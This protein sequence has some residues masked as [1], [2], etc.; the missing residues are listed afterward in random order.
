MPKDII[1][2]KLIRAYA[3]KNAIAHEGKAN[4]GAV[5]SA[6]F[7]EGLKR[8]DV[9]EVMPTVTRVSIEVS[10]MKLEE[11]EKEFNQLRDMT[12]EREHRE[13]LPELPNVPKSGVVMR[14]APAPSGPLHVG[15]IIAAM[16]SYLYFKKYGG[17]FYVRIE[18]T[19][20]EKTSPDAYKA[21]KEDC[22][23]LF[24]NKVTEYIIQSERLKIY[25][26]YAEKLIMSGDA[27]VCTCSTENFK[28]LADGKKD[29]PCRKISTKENLDRWK[30]ML[31]KEKKTNYKEG[32]AVLRFKSGMQDPNPA[33][34][35]FPLARINEHPHPRQKKK[36]RVWP[37]MNLSVT[38]DDIE[39]G[40]TYII[41][42]KDHMDNAKRQKLMYAALGVENKFP[43]T[44]FIG[45]IK[46]SDLDLSK[47]KIVAAIERGDYEGWDDEKLPTIVSLRKRGYKPTAFMKLAEQ[48]GLSEADKVMSQKDF[49]S[50]L[51]LYNR[52]E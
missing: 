9:K 51:D 43:W 20:P 25:Y 31:S 10:R 11:Q 29:C 48:R 22:D 45:K 1:N 15:H 5:V 24:E 23:W 7:V 32:E 28:K 27:Y 52:E 30:N 47:R 12:S 39:Y 44:F 19:N 17:K 33:M 46:F 8:E 3:L 36:F 37:L 38:A 50:L 49:F 14:F 6:L 21:I 2:E 13:G 26:D 42:G 35:D 40:M 4:P 41:R 16:Y 34:R 18:D